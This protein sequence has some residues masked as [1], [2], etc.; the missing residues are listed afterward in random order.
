MMISWF[1]RSEI[2]VTDIISKCTLYI[3]VDSDN[4]VTTVFP[5]VYFYAFEFVEAVR[6]VEFIKLNSLES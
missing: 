2:H 4:K 6:L 1:S 5:K 3:F